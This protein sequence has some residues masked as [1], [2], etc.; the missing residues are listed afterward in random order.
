M[1]KYD[2]HCTSC[3]ATTEHTCA[4]ADRELQVCDECNAT[5]VLLFSPPSQIIAS[6]RSFKYTFGEL[7]GTSSE[8]DYLREHPNVERINQSTF[9]TKKQKNEAKWAKAH[10]DA[11]SIEHAIQANRTLTAGSKRRS[12]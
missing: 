5:L 2:F 12:A 1:P 10:K 3:D 11:A 8:K 6:P 7:Y 9:R 4:I